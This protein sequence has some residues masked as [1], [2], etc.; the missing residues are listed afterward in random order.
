[1]SLSLPINSF[2]WVGTLKRWATELR[3]LVNTAEAFT[4]KD[5]YPEFTCSGTMTFTFT[6]SEMMKYVDIGPMV[7]FV[8]DVSGTTGGAMD[9]EVR[10]SL[11]V[12]ASHQSGCFAANT[13]IDGGASKGGLALFLNSYTIKVRQYDNALWTAGASRALRVMGFYFK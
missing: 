10:F 3:N 7:F 9:T 6:G 11:P 1:M 2:S 13:S 4:P 8:I 5:W 12:A